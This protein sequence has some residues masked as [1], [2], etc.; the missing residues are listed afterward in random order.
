MTLGEIKNR[1]A[2]VA[3]FYDVRGTVTECRSSAKSRH[4]HLQG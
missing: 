1:I 2:M 3:G 4:G